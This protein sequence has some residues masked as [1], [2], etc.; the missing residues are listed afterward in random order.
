MSQRTLYTMTAAAGIA[1]VV[2]TIIAIAILLSAGPPAEGDSAQ[3]V[4]LFFADNRVPVLAGLYVGAIS[5]A[6]NLAFY[7]LLRDV[8]RRA[9]PESEAL[10]TL[11]LIGGAVFIAVLYAGFAVLAQ[12]A[13]REGTGDP[14]TQRTLYDV[15]TLTLTMTGAPTAVS[16]V[17]LSAVILRGN[18]LPAWIAWYGL[19]VAA[20]HLV[21]LGSFARDGL[22]TP[23]I[24]AGTI[25]PLAFEVW[26]LA[27][28]A[29]LLSKRSAA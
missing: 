3:N 4:A 24:V 15:Y 7:V 23:T 19:A 10:A 1:T 16:L 11:G 9:D 22:F 20:I 21:S 5:L 12:L 14:T 6:F 17:A 18:L 13:F 25:A 26:V 2:T 28:C 27:I 29:W 8:L